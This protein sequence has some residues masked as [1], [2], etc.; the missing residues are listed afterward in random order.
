MGAMAQRIAALVHNQP[1]GVCFAC[2]ARA[3]GLREHDARAVAVVLIT[4]AGLQLTRRTC[5]SC[6]RTDDVLAVKK[7]A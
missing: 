6:H 4:R 2:L 1:S 3:D 5:S 7:T